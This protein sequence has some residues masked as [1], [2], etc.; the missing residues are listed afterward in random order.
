LEA[1]SHP[2]VL[3]P[4]NTKAQADREGCGILYER[5]LQ[6][7]HQPAGHIKFRLNASWVRKTNVVEVRRSSAV[8]AIE[9]LR[10]KQMLAGFALDLKLVRK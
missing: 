9:N 8:Q 6:P 2:V 3:R 5:G 10:E 7:L 4:N 1:A